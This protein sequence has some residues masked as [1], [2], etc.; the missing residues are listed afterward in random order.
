MRILMVPLPALAPTQGSQGRV[1]QLIAGFRAAGFEVAT[2]AAEDLNFKKQED[3]ENYFLEVPIPMGLPSWLGKNLFQLASKTG[4]TARKTVHSFDEVLFLTGAINKGYFERS[5]ACIQQAIRSYKPDLVYG[6]FNLSAI[7]AAKLEGV[8]VFTDYSYPV[9]PTYA[10]MPKLAKGVNKAIEKWGMPKVHSVLEIFK[11]AD[12]RIVPSCYELEP[13]DDEKVLFTGPFGVQQEQETRQ[14]RRNKILA[15]MGVGTIS[16]KQLVHELRQAFMG[17][18]YEVY[19]VG[20]GVKEQ[21]DKNIHCAPFM[22]FNELLPKTAVFIHHG[23][24]NSMM[25]ALRYG[26]PQLICPGKIF[27]RKYNASSIIKQGAGIVLDE[28]DFHSKQ[29]KEAVTKLIAQECYMQDSRRL[30]HEIKKLGGVASIV[31]LIQ[32]S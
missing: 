32:E 17:T 5:V 21:V 4:I 16:N 20:K 12:Y 2:C 10:S 15:Y 30:W 31:K 7:I 13:I 6:E 23:G 29:I 27:E 28:T 9:Q 14:I 8:R 11:W 18:D 25:D 19:I 26:V 1:K 24:Q 3:I 22:N